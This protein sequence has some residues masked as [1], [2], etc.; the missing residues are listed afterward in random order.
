MSSL[1]ARVY[2]GWIVLDLIHST[3]RVLEQV[4]PLSPRFSLIDYPQCLHAE[5][6]NQKSGDGL[7]RA[8]KALCVVEA[9]RVRV[10]TEPLEGVLLRNRLTC[11]LNVSVC[12]LQQATMNDGCAARRV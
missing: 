3:D 10:F 12:A 5:S 8:S 4:A 9:R 7:H 6:L 11:A 1:S 2:C